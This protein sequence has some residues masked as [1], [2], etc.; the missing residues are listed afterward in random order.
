MWARSVRSNYAEEMKVQAMTTG[1]NSRPEKLD[2]IE[3]RYERNQNKNFDFAASTFIHYNLELISWSQL[4][5]A[6]VIVGTQKEWGVELEAL[7]HTDKTQLAISHGFTKL[8]D[9]DL[10]PGRSTET[11]VE[12]YGK[13]DDL[14]NWSNHITK[15][16]GRYILDEQWTLDSSLRI[17]WGFP[18]AKDYADYYAS[19]TDY[20]LVEPGW[21]K[22]Y[23]GNYYLNAGLQYKPEKNLTFRVDGFNLLGIFNK[24]LNKRNYYSSRSAD[25]RSHAAAVAVSMIYK[26]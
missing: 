9:F 19:T 21:A 23:R 7:Y 13:G 25:Y 8:Y 16:T 6:P 2:S 17:Y 12:P 3:L 18:G 1:G 20:P 14:A 11:T 22:G 26:F 10:E 5:S 24:D 15:M 4:D